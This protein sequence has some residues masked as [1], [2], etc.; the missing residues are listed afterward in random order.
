MKIFKIDDGEYHWYAA[1]T[2][3]EAIN[4]HLKQMYEIEFPTQQEDVALFESEFEFRVGMPLEDMQVEQL[5]DNK[6]LTVRLDDAESTSVTKIC[7]EWAK[8]GP[9]FVCSTCF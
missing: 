4:M 5:D 6:E 1:S 3:K 2:A 7:K 8:E 9:C